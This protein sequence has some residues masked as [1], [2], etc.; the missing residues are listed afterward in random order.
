MNENELEPEVLS[1]RAFQDRELLLAWKQR[2]RSYELTGMVE[3][4]EDSRV[5]PALGWIRDMVGRLSEG[6]ARNS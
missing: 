2:R 3:A 6:V 4:A 5:A 1:Y